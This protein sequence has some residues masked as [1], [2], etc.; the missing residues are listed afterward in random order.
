MPCSPHIRHACHSC[1]GKTL[2]RPSGA[3]I[4]RANALRARAVERVKPKG[5]LSRRAAARQA[6]I[7]SETFNQFLKQRTPTPENMGLIERWL[8]GTAIRD[9]GDTDT[10]DP[11]DRMQGFVDDIRRL[12]ADQDL[13]PA[14]RAYLLGETRAAIAEVNA[15]LRSTALIHAERAGELREEGAN[16]RIRALREDRAE[17]PDVGETLAAGEFATGAGAGDDQKRKAGGAG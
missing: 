10:P 9:T 13:T 11:F 1:Q 5:R 8:D 4:E 15:G 7:D 2:P 6:G 16:E 14:Y 17:V 3:D 12:L